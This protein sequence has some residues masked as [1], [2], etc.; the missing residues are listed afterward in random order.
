MMALFKGPPGGGE[1]K[2]ARSIFQ[3]CPGARC[4]GAG[5]ELETKMHDVE[6]EVPDLL[7]QSMAARLIEHGF[8]VDCP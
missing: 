8:K 4:I 3:H 2:L 6:Y 1:E 7:A 5:T